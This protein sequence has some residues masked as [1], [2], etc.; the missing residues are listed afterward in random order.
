M[1]EIV[2]Y[3]FGIYTLYQLAIL[4]VVAAVQ[5]VYYGEKYPYRA[6]YDAWEA[7]KQQ[8]AQVV[9]AVYLCLKSYVL[10]RKEWLRVM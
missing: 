10:H 8:Y 2:V 9:V 7:D 1:E 3:N 4:V 5:V 6:E